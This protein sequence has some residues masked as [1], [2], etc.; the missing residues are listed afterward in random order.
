M[1]RLLQKGGKLSKV[2]CDAQ[3]LVASE[4]RG[5]CAR[6]IEI[7]AGKLLGNHFVTT[8][9]GASTGSG[10]LPLPTYTAFWHQ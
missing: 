9:S 3:R 7:D 6:I 8:G 5:R 4:W 2:R 1:Q 10:A